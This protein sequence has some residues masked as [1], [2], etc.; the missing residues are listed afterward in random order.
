MHDREGNAAVP[1][2]GARSN[3]IEG[4][5]GPYEP[6]GEYGA[7]CTYCQRKLPKQ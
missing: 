7:S 5:D 6:E 3:R 2:K 1:E 4:K